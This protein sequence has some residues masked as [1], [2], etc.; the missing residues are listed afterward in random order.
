MRPQVFLRACVLNFWWILNISGS[1]KAKEKEKKIG[2]IPL[3]MN[4]TIPD[5]HGTWVELQSGLEWEARLPRRWCGSSPELWWRGRGRG[6]C[7]R[8]RRPR[9]AAW[10][11][12]FH[13]TRLQHQA[14]WWLSR[15]Y[16]GLNF[17]H[18]KMVKSINTNTTWSWICS[19]FIPIL[20][21]EQYLILSST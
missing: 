3:V 6:R 12:P 10:S 17:Y 14:L 19:F 9:T 4:V 21:I 16:D 15:V 11:R 8:R 20:S 2:L 5:T 13:T 1:D 18:K 7:W